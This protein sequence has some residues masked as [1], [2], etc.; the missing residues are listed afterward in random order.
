MSDLPPE[1]APDQTYGVG[2]D[3]LEQQAALPL[4]DNTQPP[5]PATA[6]LRAQPPAGVDPIQAAIQQ[7]QAL[8]FSPIGLDGP[9]NYPDEPLTTGLPIGAG[10]GPEALPPMPHARNQVAEVFAVLAEARQSPE[11]A[12]LA[13]RLRSPR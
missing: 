13:E 7:A 3:Q 12:A 5:I 1:V 2:Q 8:Q 6:T 10:A 11:L 4:P 9:S